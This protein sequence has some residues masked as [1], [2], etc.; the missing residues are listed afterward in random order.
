MESRSNKLLQIEN[1]NKIILFGGSSLLA[2]ACKNFKEIGLK[3]LV[4]TSPRHA[5][6][7]IGIN[8][9]KLSEALDKMSVCYFISEDINLEQGLLKEIDQNTLGL[10]LGEAWSFNKKIIDLFDGRL[11]DFM[12]IPLPRY[13]GGAHYTW[14]ILR[15]ERNWGC[16]IQVINEDMV[17]GEFD[18]G[19]IVKSR[20]YVF[21]KNCRIP[22]DFFDYAEKQDMDFVLEFISEISLGKTF[23]LKEIKEEESLYFPR[24]N[25]IQH[26]WI[27]WSWSGEEI[28]RFICAFDCPYAGA[29]TTL[30][31]S[32][33][34]LKGAYMESDEDVFHPFQNGLITR[35]NKD[36]SIMIATTNGHLKIDEIFD[37]TGVLINNKLKTGMRF[38][39]PQEKIQSAMTFQAEYGV[40]G[41]KNA[42]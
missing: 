24:L 9:E 30:N 25:T 41:L 8:G 28:E 7:I 17:Q 36:G 14:A 32:Q 27:D 2:A 31:N 11:M 35:I 1:I 39:T 3:T 29:G 23:E 26:G 18:S 15:D 12:S 4:Y 33:V 13:R 22:Q 19:E 40:W 6:E 21:P 16:N 37:E 34:R 38:Y 10:G 42:K 5:Q 20:E